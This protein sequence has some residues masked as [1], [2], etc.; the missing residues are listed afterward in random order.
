MKLFPQTCYLKVCQI[1]S[2]PPCVV[3]SDKYL[4]ADFL[5]TPSR[6]EFFGYFIYQRMSMSGVHLE[7]AFDKSRLALHITF[8]N[9]EAK[10]RL[11]GA[12]CSVWLIYS[13]WIVNLLCIQFSN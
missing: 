5:W 4:K 3:L 11:S 10:I 1:S 2:I 7:P 12:L 8:V 13:Y 6:L 9:I